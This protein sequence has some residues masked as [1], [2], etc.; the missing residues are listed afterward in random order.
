MQY[1]DTPRTY[2]KSSVSILAVCAIVVSG[3]ALDLPVGFAGSAQ[4]E[5][6]EEGSGGKG[7]AGEGQGESGQGAGKGGQGAGSDNAG[8]G[9]G[10]P[11]A[12]SEG[13]G[14]RGGSAGATGGGKP[15]W[16]Q[17]GIPEVELGRL[18]VARS[19]DQVLDRAY[20]EAL[21]SFTP[22]MAS[23]YNLTLD[24]AIEQLS[25]NF[26]A[27]TYIDSPLQN[28]ALL[29]D[30]LDGT[31]VLNTLPTVSNSTATLSALFLGMASDKTVTISPET[32]YAVAKILGFELTEA[33]ATA[34]A[35]DAEAVRIAVLAGH[36]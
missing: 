23:F 24:Q 10:A 14:P 21:A 27:L 15:V 25:L 28:L 11:S 32:A 13:Q 2:K 30:A 31:S 3:I 36:G 29:Q 12:D 19:P 7:K 8:E 16:A 34:L 17:E 20:N 26:D 6:H 9:Q 22:E 35:D 4:A 5:S 1:L 33:Q 18:N